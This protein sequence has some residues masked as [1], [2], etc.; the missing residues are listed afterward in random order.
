MSLD[1]SS[2]H[3]LQDPRVSYQRF[4]WEDLPEHD[5]C[6]IIA[7][8]RKDGVATHGNVERTIIALSQMAHRTG[9]IEQEGDGTGIQTDIPRE[10]WKRILDD[11]EIRDSVVNPSEFTIGHL[12]IRR[13]SKEEIEDIKR[14]IQDVI[15]EQGFDVVLMREANTRPMTL[16]PLAKE[17]EPVWIQVACLPASFRHGTY[18][19]SYRTSL[20][21]ENVAGGVH[22][23]S[24]SNS[25]VVYKIR[26]DVKA[27]TA[28][29]PELSDPAYKSA[30]SLGHGRYST[31][32]V[33]IHERAQMCSTLGHNGEINT[34][35]Q[36]RRQMHLLG[37]HQ[38]RRGSDSQDVDR[39]IEGL[40]FEHDFSLM[41]AMEIVFPPV[42]SEVERMPEQLH[43]AY[44][45]FRRAFGVLAQGPAAIIARQGDELA[46]SV[47]ALGLRPLWFGETEKEIFAS[48][49]KSVFKIETMQ[50]DPFPLAPGEKRA[51][52][53]HRPEVSVNPINGYPTIT[54]GGV[55]VFEN[56]DV[57]RFVAGVFERRAG[58]LDLSIL[59]PQDAPNV[60][61]NKEAPVETLGEQRANALYTAF[62]WQ[63]GDLD[64][65]S[66]MA[67]MGK[68]VIGS[69]G[70]DGPL[71]VLTDDMRNLSDFFKERVA[72][73]T[74]PS[75]DRVREGSHFSVDVYLGARPDL[76]PDLEK[77]TVAKQV[78]LDL[79]FV[80][81]ASNEHDD[82]VTEPVL[83]TAA[84]ELGTF[85]LTELVEAGKADSGLP[86]VVFLSICYP[87]NGDLKAAIRVLEE[88]AVAAVRCFESSVLVLDDREAFTGEQGE[89]LMAIDA[90]LA[91]A[92]VNRGL[93]RELRQAHD[94]DAVSLRRTTSLILCSGA[95]RHVHDFAVA[96]GLGAD[97]LSPYLFVEHAFSAETAAKQ[98]RALHRLLKAGRDGIEKVIS[99]I[100][101][102]ELCGYWHAF[103]SIGLTHEVAALTGVRNYC[104]HAE[105][106]WGLD[107]L[108]R[109]AQERLEIAYSDRK[110]KPPVEDR[111][112]P[113]VWK[114]AGDVA[115]SKKD[116]QAFMERVKKY[117]I[118]APVAL[119]H[120]L[121]FRPDRPPVPVESVSVKVDDYDAP[122]YIP[123]MSF[124][125]QGETSFRAY[126]RAAYELNIPSINGEGGEIQDMMGKYWRHRGQQ[127][128]SA[129]FGVNARMLNSGRFIEIKIGQGA[130]PG[131]GGHLPGF[132][133]TDRIA[134]SRHTNPGVDLISPS[135]NHD[136]YSIE[137]LAQLIE[138]LKTVNADAKISVKLP[139]IPGIGVIATGVA[140]AGA[141]VIA[142]SGYD[143]GTGAARKHA[144]KHVGFPVEIGIKESHNALIENG[145][146]HLVELWGDGGQKTAE[147]VLRMI[148]LGADR[149]GF[150]TLSMVAIGCTICRDCSTGTCHTGITAHFKDREDA[151]EAGLKR[152]TPRDPQGSVERLVRLF[153]EMREEIRQRVA[154]LGFT[155]VR[156]LVG[157]SDLLHQVRRVD[158][159]SLEFLQTVH[160][161]TEDWRERRQRHA[162]GHI[163]LKRPRTSLTRTVAHSFETAI[164]SGHSQLTYL[165]DE[166]TGA[167]RAMGTFFSGWMARQ[168]G[169]L[170]ENFEKATLKISGSSVPG[171]GLGAFNAEG[172]DIEVIGGAMD[173]TAKCASG[174]RIT[175]LKGPN[176]NG[177]LIDG[178]VGKA[179]AYGA[180]GGTFIVQGN[181]DSR[182]GIRLS[183]A[184]LIFG[185]L[186]KVVLEDERGNW[187]TRANLRGFAF[188]YMTSGRALVLGDPGPW[189]CSGMTGGTIFFRIDPAMNLTEE[190]LERRLAKGSIVELSP[191]EAEDAESL[192][193]L[194]GTYHEVLTS[195]PA[196]SKMATFV[197]D[198]MQNWQ[199]SFVK[200][201][202][203][204]IKHTFVLRG[205]NVARGETKRKALKNKPVVKPKPSGLKPKPSGLK[206]GKVTLP[207]SAKPA[208]V[209]PVGAKPAMPPKKPAGLSSNGIKKVAL[210]KPNGVKKPSGPA[211]P[212]GFRPKAVQLPREEKD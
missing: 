175:I 165:D 123:A 106:G 40:M 49:E 99:T 164:K 171:N 154:A 45:Y 10:I 42:W 25:S 4:L 74:N 166:V 117:E 145:L 162:S 179:F 155:S 1:F 201:A 79:P 109:S 67:L 30:I 185:G 118:E 50:S 38:A 140:K 127:V 204:K 120:T 43:G 3:P 92:A 52:R 22:V 189:M 27:L 84:R 158:E 91:V 89:R 132:K 146:R 33:S 71:A 167:D 116:Y 17:T 148:C 100:G 139:C 69:I 68:E 156:D 36:L 126:A 153:G 105:R 26:G 186:P 28:Y 176:H 183:G 108:H 97:A 147:D 11:A 194:L 124:G 12:M 181:A 46:F 31:N 35:A 193:E 191:V 78:R 173:S 161:R 122:F 208:R 87:E 44:R 95:L 177:L 184:D 72:V 61:L 57:Q 190:A 59:E 93:E 129:R 180:Q 13:R 128:A 14:R 70:H 21:I 8:V 182:A 115:Q 18:A 73:V 29:F 54:S 41:E 144:L 65:A 195:H 37:L 83:R 6:A 58:D 212:S 187:A 62:G 64:M 34:I 82:S 20:A 200:C 5:A 56:D 199:T 203:R 98:A 80:P 136:L 119:R 104:G 205:S 209:K 114:L 163:M 111:L 174:G 160:P 211:P 206:P 150:G 55:A 143:G 53:L 39:L 94:A 207:V 19:D 15:T 66:D 125:S 63:R 85:T 2:C 159:L 24:F 134:E 16:G 113:K 9:E 60:L 202:P 210:P 131:E 196:H 135:N 151:L 133:V 197:E 149:V 168:N 112:Y 75:I 51:L 77:T 90:H 192:L 86:E 178:S 81:A 130:K 138:E 107:A 110:A 141:N 170:P 172:L 7:R 188:E 96:L 32:T 137:D 101:T 76:R 142:I 198:L 88:Q 23:A 169:E 48:S 102:H 47:D 121:E 103:A 157:R 152:Y